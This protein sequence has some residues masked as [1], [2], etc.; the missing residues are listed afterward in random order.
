MRVISLFVDPVLDRS[1]LERIS[2]KLNAK[3]KVKLLTPA[4]LPQ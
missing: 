3:I 2:Y 4:D 1:N